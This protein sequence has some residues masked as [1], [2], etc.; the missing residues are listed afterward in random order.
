MLCPS[1]LYL[2]SSLCPFPFPAD[3]GFYKLIPPI[4]N[5]VVGKSP[6]PGTH[7]GSTSRVLVWS[8]WGRL[9]RDKVRTG[10]ENLQEEAERLPS[11]S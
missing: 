6:F 4:L 2:A 10:E 5:K 11:T 1:S 3:G 9:G 8:W 7:E